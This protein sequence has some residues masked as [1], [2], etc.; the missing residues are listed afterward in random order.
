MRKQA[1][2]DGGATIDIALDLNVWLSIC[3]FAPDAAF[4]GA[5]AGQSGPAGM[6]GC[7]SGDPVDIPSICADG[8]M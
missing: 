8:P 6:Q 7:I 4:A 2:S 5:S 1:V 3:R